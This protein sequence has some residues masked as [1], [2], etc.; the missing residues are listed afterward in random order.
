MPAPPFLPPLADVARVASAAVVANP[1]ITLDDAVRA[2]RTV[3]EGSGIPA[4]TLR[5]H[6][7]FP[8]QIRTLVNSRGYVMLNQ[9]TAP[10][11]DTFYANG[12]LGGR[13]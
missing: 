6:K 7:K 10:D 3:R 11:I 4:S 8:R 2:L 9:V 13:T 5:K 12:K 1:R